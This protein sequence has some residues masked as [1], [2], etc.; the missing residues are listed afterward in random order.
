M[1]WVNA[2][3]KN[4]FYEKYY[5]SLKHVGGFVAQYELK[6]HLSS[7]FQINTR[8]DEIYNNEI[9]TKCTVRA[10]E[11]L[12]PGEIRQGEY[13]VDADVRGTITLVRLLYKCDVKYKLIRLVQYFLRNI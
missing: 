12:S 7:S 2:R 11:M 6:Q 1:N 4:I 9:S 8:S 3:K 13:S 10:R 5:V